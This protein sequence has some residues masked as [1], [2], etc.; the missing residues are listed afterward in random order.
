MF[1]RVCTIISGELGCSLSD[2]QLNATAD[3]VDGWDSL[4]H[5]RLI[6]ALEDKLGVR[7]PGERLFDLTC[8]GDL[9][10]LAEATQK[11]TVHGNA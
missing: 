11:D 6:M 7:F 1:D 8:V 3:D 4:A 5:A 10:D 9:V 2:L